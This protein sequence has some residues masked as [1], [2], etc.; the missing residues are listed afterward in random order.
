MNILNKRI[1]AW[2][3]NFKDFTAKGG[4]VKL[5]QYQLEPG[6]GNSGGHAQASRQG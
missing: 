6:V 3:R 1:R 5:H 4:G 2:T